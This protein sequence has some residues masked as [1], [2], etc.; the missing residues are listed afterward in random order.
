MLVHELATNALKH[1]A[2]SVLHGSVDIAWTVEEGT[3]DA[4]VTMHWCEQGGPPVV[5]PTHRSFGSSLIKM[6]MMGSGG[7]TVDYLPDG[8]EATF[9][10]S[11]S[12]LGVAEF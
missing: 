2:L 4:L 3:D 5:A 10:A 1:G 11:L 6:G 8:L 7:T 9:Q 12:Q